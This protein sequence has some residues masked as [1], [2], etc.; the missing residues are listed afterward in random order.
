MSNIQLFDFQGHDVRVTDQD[1]NPWFVADDF[2]DR[3]QIKNMRHALSRLDEEEKGSVVLN[4]AMGR[5]YN[6]AIIS[7]SGVYP[8]SKRY[9]THCPIG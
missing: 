8:R 2:K 3:L 7:E 5:P 4:D 6:A 1:G 9:R